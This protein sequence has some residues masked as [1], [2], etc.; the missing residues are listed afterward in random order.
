[1]YIKYVRDFEF[2]DVHGGSSNLDKVMWITP[3]YLNL[4]NCN[5]NITTRELSSGHCDIQIQHW[6]S[7]KYFIMDLIRDN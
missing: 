2:T 5:L 6:M 3:Y 4:E 7:R 1:M